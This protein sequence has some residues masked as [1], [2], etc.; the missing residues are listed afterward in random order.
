[1]L[2]LGA[3]LPRGGAGPGELAFTAYDSKARR[4]VERVDSWKPDPEGAAAWLLTTIQLSETAPVRQL[5]DASGGR[6]K[7]IDPDGTTTERI[8]L[9]ELRR[10]WQSKGL[11]SGPGKG[12][13]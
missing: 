4:L 8:E 6:L 5:Y 7:R 3:L 10:L 2:A 1:M 13:E 12:G 11:R 9:A